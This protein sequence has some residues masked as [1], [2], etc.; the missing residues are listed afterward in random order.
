MKFTKHPS[1]GRNVVRG[2]SANS[3]QIGERTLRGSCAFNATELLEQWPPNSA[4]E[5]TLEHFLPIL[6]W[7]PEIILLGTGERQI[8]PAL[9]LLAEVRA[10]GVGFEVM[11]TGAAC[12]TFNVLSSEERRVVAALLVSDG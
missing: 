11:D 8:F 3:V 5:L 4:S 2:Y 12:R 6:A 10:R 1:S 9:Q 7:E